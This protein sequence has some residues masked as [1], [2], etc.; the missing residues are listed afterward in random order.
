VTRETLDETLDRV[1]RDLTAVARD[2]TF[3]A[4]LRPQL[5][6]PVR[7]GSALRTFAAAAC[8]LAV[9]TAAV[10]L[11]NSDSGTRALTS[12][13]RPAS[14]APA[15]TAIEGVGATSELFAPR[16]E[17]VTTSNRAA[18]TG[19]DTDHSR[20]ESTIP[21]LSSPPELDVA[22]LELDPLVVHPVDVSGLEIAGLS[23]TDLGA[24]GE[25]KE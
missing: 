14:A 19:L 13:N 6:A 9:A 25:P 1:A 12:I 23:V 20:L 3:V 7:H 18:S 10:L 5:D 16:V 21:A 11:R 8:M 2:A 22:H 17:A 24:A 15:A 4:R